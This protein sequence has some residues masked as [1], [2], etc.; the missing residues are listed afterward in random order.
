M[1]S[2]SYVSTG[3]VLDFGSYSFGLSG[4]VNYDSISRSNN[5][6]TVNGANG[7]FKITGSGT[8]FSGYSVIGAYQF[9]TG[10]TRRSQ[11]FG[12]GTHNNGDVLSGSENNFS[13]TV[14]STATSVSV[15]PGGAYGNDGISWGASSSM[16]IPALGSPSLSSQSVTNIKQKTATV[17]YSAAAGSNATMSSV[18]LQ[19]GLTTSY[20]TNVSS[21]ASSGSFN[22]SNLKPGQT[23]HYRF[24]ITNG[25]GK[26]S[27]SG[28]YT[29]KTKPVAGMLPVLMGLVG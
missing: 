24:F 10:T 6:I 28:D 17:N 2:T 15:R 5:T 14:S 7:V 23:Y 16:S 13:F 3:A 12:T 18:Q 1:A 27:T 25:G 9:P 29:F 26:T 20:G 11:D 4:Y 8:Y 22:L 19:Y 21:S